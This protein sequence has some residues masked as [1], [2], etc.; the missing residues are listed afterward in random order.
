MRYLVDTDWLVEY[1]KG[2]P[3][4]VSRL[5]ELARQGAGI[6]LITYGEV[7]EGI[8]FGRNR[9]RHEAGFLGALRILDLVPLDQSIMEEFAQVRGELRSQG[10][11]IGDFDILI[12]ATALRHELTLATG[13]TRHYARIAR[14]K[15][16]SAN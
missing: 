8:Y 7:Y 4:I 10:Q 14:L 11:L 15:L 6:S 12:A 16:L 9:A 5:N 1:L 3:H 2:K 13:N